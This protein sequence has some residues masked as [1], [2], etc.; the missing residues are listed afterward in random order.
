M[1]AQDW[2]PSW[3][4]CWQ[5]QKPR[6]SIWSVTVETESERWRR[7]KSTRWGQSVH[8]WIER[9]CRDR[10]R[11]MEE[12]KKFQV[13]S[14]STLG[15]CALLAK[16]GRGVLVP[17]GF[18]LPFKRGVLALVKP[19]YRLTGSCFNSRAILECASKRL[20]TT[21]RG[22]PIPIATRNWSLIWKASLSPVNEQLRP[23]V[24]VM[25]MCLF[26]LS[27]YSSVIQFQFNCLPTP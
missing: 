27:I 3:L 18:K 9:H 25:E 26:N 11:K 5:R 7:L 6:K 14:T 20:Q 21:I 19:A 17:G 8:W 4:P 23:C 15:S 13:R 10:K 1:V 12:V 24:G 2:K 16:D 22:P